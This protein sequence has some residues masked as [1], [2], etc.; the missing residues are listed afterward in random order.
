MASFSSGIIFTTKSSFVEWFT[1]HHFA[2][3]TAL[4]NPPDESFFVVMVR[5]ILYN[6]EETVAWIKKSDM[7]PRFYHPVLVL[8]LVMILCL[9]CL[10]VSD[11]SEVLRDLL[12]GMNNI[13]YLLPK[14]FLGGLLKRRK[15]RYLNLNADV[16]AEAFLTIEDPL[17]I[18]STEN[19]SPRIHAPCAM[20]VDLRR[21]RDEIM[22][23]LFPKKNTHSDSTSEAPSS[24]P[25]PDSNFNVDPA[26]G[27]KGELVMKW[28]ILDDI[29]EVINGQ[30]GEI[31][32]SFSDYAM[33]KK[34]LDKIV[35]AMATALTNAKT[36][37]G[38]YATLLRE[39]R[40]AFDELELLS[41][42]L[43]TRLVIFS[44]LEVNLVFSSD[45]T[46]SLQ[47]VVEGL[48]SRRPMMD[49]FLN[50]FGMREEPQKLVSESR[51][52]SRWQWLRS[53]IGSGSGAGKTQGW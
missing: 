44:G 50:Q 24:N 29:S 27:C 51:N 53:F 36:C 12:F 37:A 13:A 17:L 48:Q 28:N 35:H 39:V 34:E 46:K 31:Q 43:D 49:D 4:S 45:E 1:H 2:P 18:V 3:N 21:S 11:C 16:V 32:S 22:N 15:S 40:C 7:N 19:A 33:I 6:Q 14:E 38:E 8:K 30:K 41:C 26:D 23:V 20:F 25:L 10:K 42:W 52:T 9:I 5:E 47:E